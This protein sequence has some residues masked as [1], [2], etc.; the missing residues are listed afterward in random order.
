MYPPYFSGRKREIEVFEM[1]LK[2]LKN[3]ISPHMAIIGEWAIG[4]TSL[5]RKFEDIANAEGFLTYY[6]VARFRGGEMFSNLV[7]GISAEMRREFGVGLLQKIS[8]K[9]SLESLSLS[10]FGLKGELKFSSSDSAAFPF[11]EY[12]TNV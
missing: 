9:I 1:K 11:R 8:R 4:K 12:I 10:F 2:Y 6:C 5:L 7:S 3:G